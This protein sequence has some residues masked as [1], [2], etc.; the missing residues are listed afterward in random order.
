MKRLLLIPILLLATVSFSQIVDQFNFTGALNA[1][2]WVSHSGTAGQFQSDNVSSLTYSGLAA[3]AGF[4]V[5]YVSANGEDVN[6]ALSITSDSAYYSLIINVPNTTGLAANTNN[7]GDNFFGFGQTAG[8]SVTVFGGQLR[9]RSGSV[10]GTY[11]L[12]LVNSGAASLTPVFTANMPVGTPIFVVV[13]LKRTTSPVQASLWINP[14]LGLPTEPVPTMTSTLGATAFSGFGSI[15]LRQAATTGNTQIDEIRASSIWADVTPSGAVSCN[16]TN[17]INVSACQSYEVPSGDETYVTSG[18]Y[19]DTIPNAANCDSIITINLTIKNNTTAT[20]SPVACGSYTVPSGDET[21]MISGTYMDTIPNMAGCDSILTINLTISG[22]ITYYQDFDTDGFGNAAV[23]QT[24]CAPIPGYVTNDDDCDDTNNAITVGSTYYADADSDGLGNP[25]VSQVACSAPTNFV[26]NNTDC[27]DSNNAIGAAQTYYQDLDGDTYGNPAVS[28]TVCTQPV[29]YVSDNTDCN[30]NNDT[31]YPGA[32]E[33]PNNGIDEDCNGSDLNTMG[34]T[35]GMYQFTGNTCATPVLGLT[36]AQPANATF[37][38]YAYNN[39]TCVTGTDYLNTGDWNTTSTVDTSEYYSFTVTP[40]NCYAL[41]LNQLKFMHRVSATTGFATIHVR[42]SLDDFA[43]DI[44]TMTFA[45]TASYVNETV[46]L[47]SAF[48]AVT[49][50]LEFRFFMTGA[51]ASTGAYRHEDVSL[52]GNINALTPQTYYADTDD[53]GFGDPAVPVTDCSAPAG[54]VTDNTDCDDTNEEE[55]PGA[56][57][58]ADTDNDGLGDNGTSQVSC[59]Q[60]ANYVSDNTDCDDT[61]DQIGSIV[62]YYV[63]ADGDGFGDATDAGTN[64]CAPIAGSVTNAD[65]CDDSDDQ[66]NPTATEVCDGF[67]NNCDGDIDEGLAMLTYYEDADNDSYG[68]AGST[69]TDCILPAGYVMNDDDCDDTNAAI[70]PG[71]TDNTGN[72]IDENCDGVDGVL[73]IEESILAQLSVY[74]NPGTTSVVLNMNN[75]WNGFQ[76]NFVSVD[77]KEIALTSSQQSTNEL[78]FNT[79]SL[80]SGV[81]FI[82]LTSASGTALVRWVKN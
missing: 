34:T 81:Y 21:Y 18:T 13:K 70:F 39:V 9:I 57:W 35:L 51:G 65:D 11:Q 5:N 22:S 67:D 25:A 75:G 59:T 3:S 12:A 64:S 47:S 10:A 60:P 55:F 54:Y 23:S 26:S 69:V 20:I 66:V 15:Y 50:P 24:G 32:T 33:I 28:Q 6:K 37:S 76:V 31:A 36:T 41:D 42:S 71:A 62:I 1:N 79:S 29:G 16:T 2:G 7:T 30:D 53:D 49:G 44:Y 61:D 45:V 4:K 72:A 48:D 40:A 78:E 17:T 46:A 77:G 27:D 19:M 43:A 38:N 58:Y 8:A 80:V 82:R 14:A 63:D 56:V 52:V 68:D 74:P 73:G